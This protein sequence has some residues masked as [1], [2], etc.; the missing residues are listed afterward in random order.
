MTYHQICR[1]LAAAGIENAPAEAAM[2]MA[3]FCQLNQA[4]LFLRRDEDFDSPA[5]AE[6]LQKR[7]ERYPLQYILGR[8]D[9][10][11]ETYRV[12]EHTL[13]PRPDTEHLVELAI[14]TLP[15][16]GRFI[17]LCTG[18][19]CVAISTLS[20]R[21]DCHGMGV[22]LFEATLATAEENARLNGVDDR[23]TLL[24]ADVLAPQWM[25]ALG[26]FD[27]ILS[28]PPYIPTETV[29]T[30]EAE[31]FFEP[32]AA[33][34]GG[35]DGLDFYR[36]IIGQYGPYL[37]PGGSILLEIGYDQAVSVAALAAASGFDCRIY[38]DYGGNDRVAALTPSLPNSTQPQKG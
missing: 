16:G 15:P 5:L 17:D 20:G 2:L 18:S 34:C 25:E 21:P 12:N 38:K 10:C 35:A 19:G 7:C 29:S 6:A 28:N 27:C 30:L 31:L 14:K 37:K 9:F 1:A 11:R 23:L 3:H 36:A 8:W 24:L 26:P 33:L 13:I 4:E 32:A 22:D